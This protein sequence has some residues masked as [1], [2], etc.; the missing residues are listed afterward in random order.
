MDNKVPSLNVSGFYKPI[1]L[2][3]NAMR[4]T[5]IEEDNFKMIKQ[6]NI[7]YRTKVRIMYNT[8]FM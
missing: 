5:Q 1:V 7:I 2:H 4:L 8:I 3:K 6:I